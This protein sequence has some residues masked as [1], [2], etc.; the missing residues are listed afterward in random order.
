MIYDLSKFEELVEQGY[1]RKS[2]KDD[3]VLYGYTDRCTF[4]R[5]W[6]EYTLIARGLILNKF[7]G[8]VVAKPLPKFFNLGENE[9]VSFANLP[10]LPHESFEKVDGSLGIIFNYNS[11]ITFGNTIDLTPK[12]HG[13][14]IATRGSF[15]SEQAVKGKELLKNYNF[16]SIPTST[17]ILAEIIYPENK[18]VVDYHGKQELVMLAAFNR[19]TG[20]EYH[21]DIAKGLADLMGMRFAKS[22]NHS[23]EEMIALQKTLP[24]DDEGFVVK[25]ANGLRVKIK[26]EE[27]LR[28]AKMISNM[29]PLSFWESMV[30]G[31]VNR[32]Y[33]AQLPEEF[34]PTF[35]PMVETLEKQY[36]QVLAEIIEDVKKLPHQELT[37]DTKK[38]IGLFVQGKNELHHP[39]AM[40]PYL[41]KKGNGLDKYI[42]RLIRPTGNNL[43]SFE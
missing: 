6:N 22:Y 43:V 32:T 1:L 34:R 21:T 25:Y 18:I 40:F 33:L 17:T 5:Q 11:S 13:W 30:N 7:T 28:I 2:E 19:D 42:M 36:R 14:Q 4:D 12:E 38:D 26:G 23:I 9:Q 24:K 8:E 39:S 20:L 10:N 15:Y 3:L 37:N 35:E 31:T 41:T 27:Y 16:D 29:S